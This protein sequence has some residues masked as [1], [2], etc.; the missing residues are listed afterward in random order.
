MKHHRAILLITCDDR[1]GLVAAVTQFIHDHGGNIL[2]LDEHVDLQQNVFLMRLEWSLEGFGL[3][4]D[5]LAVKFDLL[6]SRFGMQWQVHYSDQVP[7]MA[8][9]VSKLPHCLYDLLSRHEAGEFVA[10]IPVIVS[11]HPELKYIGKRFGIP[12][13]VFPIT[14]ENKP[15]QERRELKLLADNGVELVVLARYM[16]ILSPDFV[17][18][19]PNRIIN[20]HHSFLPAFPGA[21]PYHSAYERGVKIIG[22]TSHYVTAELDEGPIIEQDV[23]RVSH[24]ETIDDF[25]RHGRDL[26]K[27]VLARAV[28]WHLQRRVLAYANKTVLFR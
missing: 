8:L 19:F 2:H 28:Y 21:R 4:R 6:A 14:R 25:V 12:F 23:V 3:S 22:A 5:A 13:H 10:D 18:A 9:F 26:E 11:N 1:P 24:K 17:R 7:R 20:I 15:E 27:T 16:Q